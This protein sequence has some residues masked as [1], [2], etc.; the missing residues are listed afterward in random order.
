VQIEL[1]ILGTDVNGSD[2]SNT[3]VKLAQTMRAFAKRIR[4]H[5]GVVKIR[6]WQVICSCLV[7]VLMKHLVL[8]LLILQTCLDQRSIH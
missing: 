4:L 2:R 1:I 8:V 6:I 5:D 7:F 3:V